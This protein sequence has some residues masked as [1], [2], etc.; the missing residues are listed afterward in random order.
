MDAN[1]ERHGDDGR[2]LDMD[3]EIQ[4]IFVLSFK[5]ANFRS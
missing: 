4:S 2:G 5:P 3:Q 1:Q